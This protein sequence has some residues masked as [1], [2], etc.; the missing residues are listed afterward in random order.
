[1]LVLMLVSAV[2]IS[3]ASNKKKTEVPAA[4]ETL[5]TPKPIPVGAVQVSIK[6]I[7]V[8]ENNVT[9]TVLEV[10]G[11]GASANRV[12]TNSEMALAISTSLYSVF[13]TME[14]GTNVNV[15]ITHSP[16]AFN[17]NASEWRIIKILD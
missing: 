3:C 9:G 5:E 1:M 4:E 8:T 2:L 14:T 13:K 16:P 17:S 10:I 6:L 7:N 11:Y 12:N 15:E